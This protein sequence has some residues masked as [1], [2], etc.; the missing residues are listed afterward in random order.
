MIVKSILIGNGVNIAFSKNDDYKNYKIIERL[1]KYLCTNRYDDVFQESITSDEL[2]IVLTSLNDFFK[3][4]LKGVAALR[5]TQ[6]EDELK[7]LIDIARQYK[8]RPKHR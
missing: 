7:I 2:Q 6:D 4:M 1:T 5:L 3:K 8:V